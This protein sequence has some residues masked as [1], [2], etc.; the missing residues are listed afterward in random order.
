MSRCLGQKSLLERNPTL[1]RL[2]RTA[3]PYIDPLDYMQLELFK[4][5]RNGDTD[6]R[7]I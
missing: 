1:A 4:R 7:I 2:I 6:G 5:Y 3:S